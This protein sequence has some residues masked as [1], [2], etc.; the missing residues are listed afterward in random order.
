VI[1]PPKT[2]K[3]ERLRLRKAKLSDAEAIFHQYAQDPEVIKYVSWRAHKD[4]AETR[5]YMR[6]CQLAW[7]VGKAFHWVIEH[8]DDK[9]VIGM[10]IAR[11]SGEKWELGYVL[12]RAHWGLGYMTEAL[13][14]LVGWALKQQEIYRIWAVCDV[15]NLA[16]ARVME[17]TGM[18]REGILR[19]WSVHPNLSNE[20]RDSYCYAIVK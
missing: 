15:E 17:K 19:R 9:Q 7:D 14:A 12:A 20:P 4:L 16:S 5:E 13:K 10:M 8:N 11:V 3:T 18:Q 1:N 6:M 2:L